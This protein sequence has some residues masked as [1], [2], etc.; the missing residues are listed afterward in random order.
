MHVGETGS[1]VCVRT[2][3]HMFEIAELANREGE[4]MSVPEARQTVGTG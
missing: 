3:R 2:G 1:G 4:T